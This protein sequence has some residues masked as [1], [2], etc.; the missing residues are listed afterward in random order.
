MKTKIERELDKNLMSPLG[1]YDNDTVDSF[2]N[3]A[4]HSVKVNA[5]IFQSNIEKT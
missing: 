5:T 4:W 1:Y 3:G 2:C